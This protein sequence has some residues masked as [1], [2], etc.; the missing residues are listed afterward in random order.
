[1]TEKLNVKTRMPRAPPKIVSLSEYGAKP[2]PYVSIT[3]T[4]D[5]VSGVTDSGWVQL[6][7]DGMD[8]LTDA[9]FLHARVNKLTTFFD[10]TN[11]KLS[12]IE[13][14]RERCLCNA[15][16]Y[17]PEPD[18]IYLHQLKLIETELLPPGCHAFI[19]KTFPFSKAIHN[20]ETQTRNPKTED[21]N[22]DPKKEAATT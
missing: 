19:A 15:V 21:S 22:G 7:F 12:N 14:A 11:Q 6:V 1:M 9:P 17:I 18:K 10:K 3:T 4:I 2:S 5:C 13:G 8:V 16:L 20:A